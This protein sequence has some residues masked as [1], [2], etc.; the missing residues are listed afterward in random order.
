MV[1][2]ILAEGE[3]YHKLLNSKG[4]NSVA[5]THSNVSYSICCNFLVRLNLR[6]IQ[7][8]PLK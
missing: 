5:A 7:T 2:R 1:G 6:K 4:I 3:V 8:R